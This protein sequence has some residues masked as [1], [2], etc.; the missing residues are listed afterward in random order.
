MQKELI[1]RAQGTA[2]KLLQ[3]YA[4]LD[5]IPVE[6]EAIACGENLRFERAY[7]SGCEARLLRGHSGRGFVRISDRIKE[8]GRVRFALAHELGHFKMHVGQSQVQACTNGDLSD[9]RKKPHEAQA[10]IFA[11]EILMPTVSFRA[12][13]AKRGPTFDEIGILSEQ[14]QVSLTAAIIRY[15]DLGPVEEMTLVCIG[16]DRR[17]K[18]SKSRYGN[19][20]LWV[21][22]GMR[23]PGSSMAES[24][25]LAADSADPTDI[26]PSVW[27]N[28]AHGHTMTEE[29]RYMVDYKT[30]MSLLVLEQE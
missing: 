7:L 21:E 2:F 15:I 4:Q 16:P 10:N 6:L 12:L 25:F 17:V 22:A 8:P 20:D 30:V 5:A 9:Y 3:K 29:C 13:A 1:I 14:F 24:A 26:H 19:W 11:S 18:W 27:F 28:K 23:I